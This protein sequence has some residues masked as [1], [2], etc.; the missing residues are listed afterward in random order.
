MKF[1]LIVNQAP[2]AGTLSATAVRLAHALQDKHNKIAAVYFREEGVYHAVKGE[3]T[4]GGS[5]DPHQAWIEF[6]QRSQAPLLVCSADAQRR[7]RQ[8]D[9][10]YE[11]AGLPRV[12]ELM[13]KA[14]RILTF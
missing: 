12:L 8:F 14:D 4:D 1:L 11:L 7:F 9:E 10:G 6:A 13:A 3:S 5:S 2:W